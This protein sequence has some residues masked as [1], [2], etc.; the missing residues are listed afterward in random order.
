MT[1]AP[2]FIVIAEYHGI[3]IPDLG[4]HSLA[5]CLK[6]VWLKATALDLAYQIIS[7]P[8]EM[9]NDAQFC[10][11]LGLQPGEWDLMGCALGYAKH[12]IGPSKRPSADEVTVW[13]L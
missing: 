13:L 11:L 2:Y 9:N 6:N 1:N 4:Q 8:A 5:H 10:S 7:A 3:A 12:P